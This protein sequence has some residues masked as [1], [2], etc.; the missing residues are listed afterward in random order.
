MI[1]KQSVRWRWLWIVL[2]F[3]ASSCGGGET[4]PTITSSDPL[5]TITASTTPINTLTPQPSISGAPTATRTPRP[6]Y[7]RMPRPCEHAYLTAVVGVNWTYQ[8]SGSPAGDFEFTQRVNAARPDGFTLTSR[9]SQENYVHTWA[10]SLDGLTA[11]QFDGVAAAGIALAGGQITLDTDSVEGITLPA[12]LNVGD[13]WQQTYTVSGV[14]SLEGLPD[15]TVSGTLTINNEV[16][17]M[18]SVSVP[19]GS[20]E[21]LRI[22]S[23]YVYDVR[24][25]NPPFS[26]SPEIFGTSDS[27]YAEHIGLVKVVTDLS[28]IGDRRHVVVELA[29]YSFAD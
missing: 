7:T 25:G 16:I 10:C 2:A 17:G 12:E 19:F 5:A 13:R 24:V 11:W 8:V 14:Q 27:Y 23:Y 22:H 15:A 4:D 6:T 9:I 28:F 26:F 21:A 29:A 20:F 3:A 18:E 1:A